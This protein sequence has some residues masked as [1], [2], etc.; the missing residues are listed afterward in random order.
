[1]IGSRSDQA[2]PS[3]R[4][5]AEDGVEVTLIRWMLSLTPAGRLQALQQHIRSACKSLDDPPQS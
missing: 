2:P 5:C 3:D 4:S 1:V